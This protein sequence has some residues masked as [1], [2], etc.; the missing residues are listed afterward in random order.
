MHSIF[1]L[2]LVFL[3]Q[4]LAQQYAGDKINNSLPLVP[5]SELVYF[6]IKDPAGRNGMLTL[7][8]YQSLQQNQSQLDPTVLQRAVVVIH[9]LNQDPGTYMATVR[10]LNLS[11]MVSTDMM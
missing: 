8:N 6:K 5:G 10:H 11:Y 7:I 2:L 1:C 3:S 9:G 4:A